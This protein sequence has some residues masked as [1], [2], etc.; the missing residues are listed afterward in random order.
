MR[1]QRRDERGRFTPVRFDNRL[2]L[3]ALHTYIS[4]VED[5]QRSKSS[6]PTLPTSSIAVLFEILPFQNSASESSALSCLP[7]SGSQRVAPS[8]LFFEPRRRWQIRQNYHMQLESM[9]QGIGILPCPPPLHPQYILH[10]HE[11]LAY[12][13]QGKPT[14]MVLEASSDRM[15]ST[16]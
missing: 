13:L 4:T 8:P 14:S 2:W 12:L 10:S 16:L 3:A 1:R 15:V 5:M 11:E 9:I 6:C 7:V